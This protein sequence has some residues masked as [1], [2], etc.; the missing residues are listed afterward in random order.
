MAVI[1]RNVAFSLVY[2]VT[3]AALAMAGLI[4][5]LLAAVL[6]PAS[7]VTVVLASWWG[8]TFDPPP[9]GGASGAY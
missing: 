4:N 8:H 7:S 6:M 3:G 1:R 5:P 2:N 9:R